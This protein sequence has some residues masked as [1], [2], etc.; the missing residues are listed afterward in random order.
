M[1]FTD[2]NHENFSNLLRIYCFKGCNDPQKL[3]IVTALT[4]SFN[5][6]ITQTKA[7]MLQMCLTV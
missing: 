5:Y 7:L 2:F 4:A 6:N 1:A 3:R